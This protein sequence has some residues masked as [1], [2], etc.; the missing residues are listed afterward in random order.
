M[1]EFY[2]HAKK[3]KK[4]RRC[5]GFIDFLQPQYTLYTIWLFQFN[6]MARFQM[7]N[8]DSPVRYVTLW[9]FNTAIEDGPVEMMFVFPWKEW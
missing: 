4:C 9:K 2:G 3:I 5:R 7:K 8:A 1:L 6:T